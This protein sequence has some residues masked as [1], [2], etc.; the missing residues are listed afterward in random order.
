MGVV[1]SLNDK[2]ATILVYHYAGDADRVSWLVGHGG[3]LADS[4]VR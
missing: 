2:H 4:G 1:P 3:S